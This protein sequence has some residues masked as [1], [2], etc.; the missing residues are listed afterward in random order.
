[1]GEIAALAA[2]RPQVI[3]NGEKDPGFPISGTPAQWEITQAAYRDAGA[4]DN[5]RLIIGPEGHR[6]YP[7]LAWPVFDELLKWKEK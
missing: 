3:V 1:M 6:F 7:A 2:P 5:V 4:A